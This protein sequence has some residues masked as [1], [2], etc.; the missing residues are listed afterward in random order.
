[1]SKEKAADAWRRPRI[2][3]LLL[4][5]ILALAVHPACRSAGAPPSATPPGPLVDLSRSLVGQRRILRFDG[6]KKNV[7]V[8][9]QDTARPS[10]PCDVAVEIK[11]AAFTDG[12]AR[13]VL[14][15]IGQPRLEGRSR[16]KV[17]KKWSC[18]DFPTQTSLAISGLGGSSAE[19]LAAEVGRVLL[20]VEDYLQ[21]HG[22][23]FDRPAGTDPKEVADPA[24]TAGG[25]AQRLARTITSA[26]AL[27]LAID[28]VYRSP[29][30]KT[31]YEG[32]VEFI[33]TVGVDGRLHQPRLTTPLGDHDERVLKV[34]PLWR[35]EPARRGEEPV[36][37]RMSGKAILRIY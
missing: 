35:Y 29:R 2:E 32:E 16:E 7:S 19:T 10:G 23:R 26:Q 15:P 20:S 1:M 34:L 8:K 37:V 21:V 28:P 12:L 25:E 36:A 4:V 5:G 18:R 17:G 33:A 9:L 27:L 13:F 6:K 24:L 31:P 11:S 14:E 3:R 30:R 22:V